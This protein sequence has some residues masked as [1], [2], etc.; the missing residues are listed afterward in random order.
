MGQRKVYLLHAFP[1][2]ESLPADANNSAFCLATYSITAN[3]VE[4]LGETNMNFA[5]SFSTA[6]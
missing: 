5:P 2:I 4:L 6:S 1:V 3:T